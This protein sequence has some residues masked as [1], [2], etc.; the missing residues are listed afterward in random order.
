[1]FVSAYYLV[2][3]G[4]LDKLN[5]HQPLMTDLKIQKEYHQDFDI[6]KFLFDLD[7]LTDP[8]ARSNPYW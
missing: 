2:L 3:H 1:M 5:V 6:A 8:S 4:I 7:F